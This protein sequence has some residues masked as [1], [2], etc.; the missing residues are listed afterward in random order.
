MEEDISYKEKRVRAITQLYYS[1]PEI[2]DIIFKFSR[3]REISPRYF[4]GFGKRPDSFQYPGDIFSLVKRGATSFHCSEEIWEDPMTLSTELSQNQYN[5][6]RIGW[7][8]LIDIDCKWIEYS[9]LAAISIINVLKSHGISGVSV[10]FSGSKGF[11]ILVPFEAFPEEIAGE[12]TKNLFPELPRKLVAYLR[13]KAGKELA[14][15]LPENFYEQFKDVKIKRGVKCARCG[16]IAKEF[17]FMVQHCSKCKQGEQRRIEKGAKNE[18]NCPN[19]RKPFD[20]V[21][22][23]PF[24]LCEKCNLDSRKSPDNFSAS[25][26]IDLFELMGLDLVLVSPRHLFRMPYSLHEKTALASVVLDFEELKNFDF[27][28]A[29]PMTV[30]LKSFTPETVP[31]EAKEFVIQALDWYQEHAPKE[32]DERITGKYAD[33]KPLNLENINDS[34][35]PPCVKNIL[36]GVADGKKRALFVLINIFR[37]V[38]MQKEDMEKRIYEWNKKNETPLKE[39]YII[40]QLSWAYKRKPILPPN[41]KDFYQGIGCCSPDNV[42]STIKNPL[43]YLVKK[44][45]ASNKNSPSRGEDNNKFKKTK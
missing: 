27:K 29:N 24:Y 15:L 30:K 38:G 17:D 37:S 21:A 14:K 28:D 3:N 35:F 34:Q 40:S 19:C 39:G 32:S 26:E 13:N 18:F 25:V 45:F 23:T 10:K 11:H 36:K 44:N 12:Q 1:K 4:E 2:Q 5:E 42:C 7:D 16:E 43:N 20:K 8:L 22:I 6:M 31:G 9:K 33:Y 41:C